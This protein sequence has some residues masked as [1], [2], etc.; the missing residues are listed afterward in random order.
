MWDKVDRRI[1]NALSKVR[2]AFR[3]DLTMTASG[4][5]VQFVQANGLAGE[6]LQDNEL[7]QHYGFTSNPLPGTMAIVLPIGGKT[8]HGIIIAT[9]HGSYRLKSL[10]PGEVALYTDEGDS[11]VLNRGRIINVTTQTLNI[12]ASKEVNINTPQLNASQ[13]VTVAGTLAANGGM[14][15]QAGSGGGAAVQIA[16]DAHITGDATIGGKGFL[17]HD[18]RDSMGGIV[19]QPL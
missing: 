13:Q 10:A 11:I 18:H 1:R 6:E 12:N 3:A 8:A 14:T 17:E 19:S 4:G 9:E 16:G 5:N 15:A 7:F 2:L